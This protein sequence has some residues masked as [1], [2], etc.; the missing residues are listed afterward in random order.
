MLLDFNQS[1]SQE[2][3]RKKRKR[4]RR[5]WSMRAGVDGRRNPGRLVSNG[6]S[7]LKTAITTCGGK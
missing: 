6:W 4:R 7:Q 1:S 5:W 2:E 3:Q